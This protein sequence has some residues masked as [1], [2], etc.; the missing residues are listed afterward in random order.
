MA[1]ANQMCWSALAVVRPTPNPRVSGGFGFSVAGVPDVTGDGAG[2]LLIGA[3]LNPFNSARFD[4]FGERR[5]YLI[6]GATGQFIQSFAS[7]YTGEGFG[8]HVGVGTGQGGRLKNIIAGVQREKST[9][10]RAFAFPLRKLTAANSADGYRVSL[11]A[12]EEAN[13]DLQ[14]SSDLKAWTT[15]ATLKSGP[16]PPTFLD[17][18]AKRTNQRFYRAQQV[19]PSP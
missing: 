11:I 15:I 13:H 8:W 7:P 2:E 18:E 17:N 10:G 16:A 3:A 14:I 4:G 5:M 12:T 6:N 19:S 1:T 9:S